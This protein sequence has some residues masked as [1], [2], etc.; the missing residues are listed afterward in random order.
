MKKLVVIAILAAIMQ[1]G[2]SAGNEDSYSS[3]NYTTYNNSYEEN[4]SYNYNNT[5][6]ITVNKTVTTTTEVTEKT[7]EQTAEP[8][9]KVP[10]SSEDS[11]AVGIDMLEESLIY[12]ESDLVNYIGEPI[13]VEG[14]VYYFHIQTL[15]EKSGIMRVEVQD[16]RV[17]KTTWTYE[18]AN[19]VDDSEEF[20]NDI[21]NM[22]ERMPYTNISVN[23]NYDSGAP[24]VSVTVWL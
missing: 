24:R 3:T 23:R 12:Y 18:Y 14:D 7:P 6:N 20:Y 22:V 4:N 21:I 15:F 2:C 10:R 13:A 11:I 16:G 17:V 1:V 19:V 8:T 9:V 5:Q